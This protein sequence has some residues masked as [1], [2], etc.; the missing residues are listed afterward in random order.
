M[1]TSELN[2]M[3]GLDLCQQYFNEEGAKAFRHHFGILYESM[4]FGLAGDRGKIFFII[5]G[6]KRRHLFLNEPPAILL[7]WSLGNL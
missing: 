7:K 3:K 1:Q 6:F 5:G 2:G 4:A